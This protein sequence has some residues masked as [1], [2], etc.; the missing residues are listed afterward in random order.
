MVEDNDQ[1]NF[2]IVLFNPEIPTNT[3]NIGRLCVGTN[4]ELHL[5]KPIKFFLNDKYLKRAGLDYWEKVKLHVHDDWNNFIFFLDEV[6]NSE[7]KNIY[8]CETNNDIKYTHPIY[9]Q[10]DIFVF[11]SESKGLPMSFFSNKSYKKIYIPMSKEIRSINICNTVA[12]ILYEGLRQ[13][14]L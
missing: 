3:G 8:L 5:I 12:I 11:G 2:R 6:K 1:I 14:N 4:S 10:G 9:E 13:L 7:K